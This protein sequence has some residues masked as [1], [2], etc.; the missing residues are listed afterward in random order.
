MGNNGLA[1]LLCTILAPIQCTSTQPFLER[2]KC[3]HRMSFSSDAMPF[4]LLRSP[5]SGNPSSSCMFSPIHSASL[6]GRYWST[7]WCLRYAYSSHT[8][9]CAPESLILSDATAATLNGFR[10]SRSR[11]TTPFQPF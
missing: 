6:V 3:L 11:L 5:L 1:W 7:A 9:S 2:T 4:H 8:V 10:S